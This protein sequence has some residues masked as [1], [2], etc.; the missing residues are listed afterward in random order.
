MSEEQTGGT[1]S[2]AVVEEKIKHL[3]ANS[4]SNRG[5][6]EK[7]LLSIQDL[8]LKLTESNHHWE[9][10]YKELEHL[11]DKVRS[12]ERDSIKKIKDLDNRVDSVEKHNIKL[13][14]GISVVI[15]IMQYF[16]STIIETLTK[17]P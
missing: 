17:K 11:N 10:L 8:T 16:G 14:A 15:W 12:H 1:H 7:I 2:L 4:D 3:Q 6:I 13:I 9:L 5:N